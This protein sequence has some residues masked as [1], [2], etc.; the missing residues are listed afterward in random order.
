MPVHVVTPGGVL[1]CLAE[2]LSAGGALLSGAPILEPGTDLVV[3]LRLRGHPWHVRARVVR[4]QEAGSASAK[5]A[6]CF[7]GIL[8]KVQDLIQS[9]VLTQLRKGARAS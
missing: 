1:P 2:N 9:Y 4:V 5:M 7:P 6:V 3:V 8:A